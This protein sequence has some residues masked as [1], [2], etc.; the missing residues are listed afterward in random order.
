MTSVSTFFKHKAY[1]FLHCNRA[2]QVLDV[3]Q[4]TKD[5]TLSDSISIIGHSLVDFFHKS[6][7]QEVRSLL[8]ANTCNPEQHFTHR[9]RLKNGRY[10][11]CKWH[12][13]FSEDS[14]S[15]YIVGEDI[16]EQKR[17]RSAMTVLEKVTNTGYWEIDL[18]TGYLYWSRKVHEIHETDW[19]TFHPKLEDGLRFYPPQSVEKLKQALDKLEKNGEPLSLIHI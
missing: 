13:D 2:L 12:A 17:I 19:N 11:W 5:V 1:I 4:Y 7:Q 9:W 8:T 6:D 14:E 16:S 15:I 10:M 3:N 18:D